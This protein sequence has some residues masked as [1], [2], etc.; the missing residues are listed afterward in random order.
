MDTKSLKF[1]VPTNWQE[2]LLPRLE[3]KCVFEVYGSLPRDIIGGGR[4]SVV[5]PHVSKKNAV[6]YIKK[7]HQSGL[8]FNYLLNATCMDNLEWSISWHKKF[9]N[10]MDYLVKS[11]VDKVTVSIPYLLELVKENYPQLKISVSVQAGTQNLRQAKFW[12]SLGADEIT[13]FM[14]INRDFGL[15]RQIRK[16]V[17]LK[18]KLILNLACLYGCPFYHYHA[19]LNSHASQKGHPSKSFM[20]DYC[21]L[22]CRLIKFCSPEELMRSRW[23]RPEDIKVYEDL[24][25]DSLKFV[26][27][28]MKTEAIC[29]IVNAYTQRSYKGNLFD[30]FS[31]PSKN[32][33]GYR[34]DF[35]KILYFFK[36]FRINIFKFFKARKL[37]SEEKI[38][39]N[40][41]RLDNFLSF[42]INNDCSKLSCDECLYCKD[43]ADEVINFTESS[44]EEYKKNYKEFLDN[45]IKGAFFRYL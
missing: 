26:N 32:L 18:L 40:N 4:A 16:H 8:E 45:L 17:T 37:F 42:F 12:E 3:K 44:Q 36:P 10:F 28:D 43:K 14:D 13:L 20:I 30:L 33:A 7:V 11:G 2:D 29:L 25:I 6:G 39:I 5:L 19:N 38:Y 34:A 24:G 41:S 9:R 21:S 22:R 27:R 31:S 15:L 23:I 35:R 1:S